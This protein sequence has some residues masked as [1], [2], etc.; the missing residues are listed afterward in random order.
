MELDLHGGGL[1]ARGVAFP[2][3]GFYLLIGRGPDFAWSAT[4][5]R[6]DVV[7]EFVETLCG[8]GDDAYS[9]RATAARWARSTPGR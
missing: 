5:A 9:T 2:G 4:S 1:D 7:D 6:S 8:N 3:V